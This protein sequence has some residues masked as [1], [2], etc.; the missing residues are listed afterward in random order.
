[1]RRA[2]GLGII[3]GTFAMLIFRPDTG[4][5]LNLTSSAPRGLWMVE[6]ASHIDRDMWISVCPP[7]L[8]VTKAMTEYMPYGDCP[9]LGVVPLLKPV[10]AIAGDSVKIRQGWNVMVN[11]RALPNTTARNNMPTWEEGEYTVKPG[12]VWLFSSYSAGSFDS[13]YFGPVKIDQ[14][15]GK[16]APLF[17]ED[18]T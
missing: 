6:P 12:E 2:I 7:V 11:G 13:R 5:R 9:D 17:T 4:L 15:R 3:A 14:V 8:P 16:A 10:G 18:E 1:M